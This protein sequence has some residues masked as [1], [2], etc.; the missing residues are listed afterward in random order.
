MTEQQAHEAIAQRFKTQWAAL[1]P[2]MPIVLGNEV[3]ESAAEWVRLAIVPATSR[4]T[5]V[6]GLKRWTREGT[7]GV[8]IFTPSGAGTARASELADDA[9]T[10]L[11]GQFLT[12]SG[13]QEPVVTYGG[14]SG[15]PLSDGA[16]F[17]MTVTFGYRFDHLRA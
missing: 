3:A 2:S 10:A 11:E 5:A 6:G 15:S 17:Q 9:R 14:S 8:Q 4:Q 7:I 1:H 12:V 16:W 13:E